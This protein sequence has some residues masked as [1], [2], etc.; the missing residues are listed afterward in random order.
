MKSPPIFVEKKGLLAELLREYQILAKVDD[1]SL[2]EH[3]SNELKKGLCH[4]EAVGLVRLMIEK[5]TELARISHEI[6]EQIAPLSPH[7]GSVSHEHSTHPAAGQSAATEERFVQ[8]SREKCGL[9]SLLPALS[10]NRDVIQM[11][12]L[13]IFRPAFEKNERNDLIEK[14]HKLLPKGIYDNQ[15][16]ISHPTALES[17]HT[18]LSD[19]KGLA[20]IR[21]YSKGSAHTVLMQ[22]DCERQIYSFYNPCSKGG[23]Y[24]YPSL[25]ACL[26]AVWHFAQSEGSYTDWNVNLIPL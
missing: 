6:S 16:N 23:C 17:L 19:F 8:R 21:L 24:N 14:M 9:G 7:L 18:P 20:L 11:E 13:E 4:G 2:S 12:L 1:E 25:G 26:K 15:L 10:S 22:V 5:E 3:I